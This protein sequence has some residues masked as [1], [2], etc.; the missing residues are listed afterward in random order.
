MIWG[1]NITDTINGFRAIRRT[2]LLEMNSDPTGFDIEYQ[3]TIR[4]LKMG[5]IIKEIWFLIQYSSL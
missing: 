5:H 1:G 4:G 3:V 2:K